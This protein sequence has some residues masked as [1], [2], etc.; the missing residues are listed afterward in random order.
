MK[1]QRWRVTKVKICHVCKGKVDV[2][3]VYGVDYWS[4]KN[5]P[6]YWCIDCISVG[7]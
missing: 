6:K 4:R 3:K 2:K 7:Y 5:N 1:K